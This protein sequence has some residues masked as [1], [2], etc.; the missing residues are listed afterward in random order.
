MW[1]G[2]IQLIKNLNKTKRL[3]KMGCGSCYIAW[4]WE[5]VH[6]SFPAFGLELKDQ[7]FWGLE[8]N[9]FEPGTYTIGSPGSQAFR[10]GLT[11]HFSSP[12]L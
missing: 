3:S 2:L 10:L 12:G 7:L 4:L 5:L 11:L 8:S 6:W 9:G 1:V